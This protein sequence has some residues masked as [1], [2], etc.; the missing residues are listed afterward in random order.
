MNKNFVIIIDPA[1]LREKLCYQS[2]EK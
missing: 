1:P 2:Q